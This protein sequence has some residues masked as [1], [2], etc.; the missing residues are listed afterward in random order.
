MRAHTIASVL[1][2]R[3]LLPKDPATEAGAMQV[4]TIV[5]NVNGTAPSWIDY[6]QTVASTTMASGASTLQAVTANAA[7]SATVLTVLQFKTT[8]V[9]KNGSRHA[10]PLLPT[11]TYGI[12][13]C[14]WSL[15]LHSDHHL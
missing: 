6:N 13:C 7:L 9:Y 15:L 2:V 14:R 3:Q 8:A 4:Q 1:E 11:L 12:N 5:V 10:A